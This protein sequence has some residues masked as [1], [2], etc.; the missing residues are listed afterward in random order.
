MSDDSFFRE[1]NEDLRSERLRTFW[2]RYGWMIITGFILVV[3]ATAAWR[4]YEYWQSQKAAE[5]G[6]AFL[7]ALTLANEGQTEEALAAFEVL[8]SEGHGAYPVLARMRAATLRADAGDAEAAIATFREIGEDGAAPQAA[9]EVAQIRAAYLLVDHGSYDDVLAVAGPLATENHAFRNSAR[10]PL[11]LAAWK[12][13]DLETA[14]DWFDQIASDEAAPAGFSQRADI[15]LDLIAAA[16]GDAPE[17]ADQ[18]TQPAR[19][20]DAEDGAGGAGAP[21]MLEDIA[22]ELAPT[23]P[24]AD[25]EEEPAAPEAPAETVPLEQLE[26]NPS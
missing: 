3:V 18:P 8:Q 1:V 11:G 12:A 14:G 13:G 10:E 19:A 6:D 5:S 4:G 9:R 22:P 21:L 25:A 16:S 23:A 26:E 20:G 2:A 24:G 7:Q 15:M 17:V